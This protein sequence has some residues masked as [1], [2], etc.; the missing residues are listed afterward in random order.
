MIMLNKYG[1]SIYGFNGMVMVIWKDVY[2]CV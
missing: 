2:V 1:G